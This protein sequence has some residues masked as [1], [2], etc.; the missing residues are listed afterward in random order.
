[1]RGVECGMRS[2][3]CGNK[4]INSEFRIPNSAIESTGFTLIEMAVVI[5][6]ISMVAL[7]VLPLLPSTDTANLRNT[8]RSLATVIRYLGD[9][10]VT[11]K[12]PHRMRLDMSDN[13]VTVKKI[14]DGEE[15]TPDD[16]FFSR[17][18]MAEGV[19]I[20]DIEIPRLGKLG[21]GDVNVDFGVSGLEESLVIHLKGAKGDHFTVTALPNGRR[22]EVLEGY[23]EKTL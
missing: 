6:I 8:A 17:K 1:M 15:V 7:I 16:P 19:S 5:V 10:G 9:R 2:A 22:V 21:E 14:V 3:Q 12:I 11:T 13:T 20:E 4:A 23:Q 18:I